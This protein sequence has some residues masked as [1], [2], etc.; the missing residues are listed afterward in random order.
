MKL[1]FTEEQAKIIQTAMTKEQIATIRDALAT[2]MDRLR[3][4]LCV[5]YAFD[6]MLA[7]AFYNKVA[8]K[9]RTVDEG[10]AFYNKDLVRD[11]NDDSEEVYRIC[12]IDLRI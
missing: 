8:A 11:S 3:D 1:E 6:D 4:K 10:E 7:D 2:E 5:L 9:D 12:S